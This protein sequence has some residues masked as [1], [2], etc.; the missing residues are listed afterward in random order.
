L[1]LVSTI[2]DALS[3][4][5]LGAYFLLKE[6]LHRDVSAVSWLPLLCLVVY[7]GAY[8]LGIGPLP[9]VVMSEVL[10]PNVKGSAGAIVASSCWVTSFMLTNTFQTF[11]DYVGRYCAFWVF[12]LHCLLAALFVHYRVPETKGISLQEIQLRLAGKEQE[13]INGSAPTQADAI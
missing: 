5:T 8:C 4:L 9:W 6:Q 13:N 7:I 12:G 3:L 1:L 10:P 11:I 2:V